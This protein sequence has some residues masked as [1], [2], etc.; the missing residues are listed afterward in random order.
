MDGN[1]IGHNMSH[2][3]DQNLLWKIDNRA[4]QYRQKIYVWAGILI[5]LLSIHCSLLR[6]DIDPDRIVVSDFRIV[7]AN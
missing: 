5:K 4:A 3:S 1:I 7:S 2:W 6:N